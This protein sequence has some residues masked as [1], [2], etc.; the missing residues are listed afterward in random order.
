M[1]EIKEYV[2][3]KKQNETEYEHAKR[4]YEEAKYCYEIKVM[5]GDLTV[6][7]KQAWARGL[8]LEKKAME[9]LKPSTCTIF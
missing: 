5:S 7:E 3:L 6:D 4:L 1:A 2:P 9:L 8:E